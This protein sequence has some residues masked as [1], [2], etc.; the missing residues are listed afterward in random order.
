MKNI[1]NK[2]TGSNLALFLLIFVIAT[3]F[4]LFNLGFSDLWSDEIYT[5]SMLTGSL[6]DLYNKFRNDLHP[7]LYYLGLRLFTS[8]FGL[9]A[10][11]LRVFSILGVLSI[12]LLGYFAGQ[13]IFGKQGAVYFC[14]MLI[15]IPM[16]ALYSHEARMYTWAAFSVTGVF[17]YSCLFIKEAE[18]RDL[19]LLFVFT[20]AAMYIHYYSMVAAFVANA[21]VFIY[22]LLT[23]NKKW[24]HHLYSLILA[25]ILFLPW[26]SMFVVQFKKVQHAFWAPAVDFNTIL[27]CFTVPFSEQYWTTSLSIA[28]MISMYS[29]MIF[30]IYRSF[31]KSFSEYRIAFWLALSIFMGTL[32]VVTIISLF[33]SPI[34]YFRYVMT[35]VTMLIVPHTILFI[36][37]KTKLLKMVLLAVILFL[38][39]RVSISTFYFS[40]GPYKQTIDY[41]AKTY[42]DIHKVLHITE[43]TAGPMVE[44][45]GK[46]GLSHYWLKAKMSNVDAFPE[47]HQ[48]KQP[49]EFLQKGEVFC[50]VQFNNLELNKENL[51]LAI[52]ESELIKTDTVKD[53]KVENGIRILVYLLKYKGK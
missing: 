28:L 44:Y 34:L 21:F 1:F 19:L 37:M 51:D 32:L 10:I 14:L 39:I 27:S 8:V 11:S 42:P 40:W 30:A 12:L 13:R 3:F 15:S 53:N 47:V 46:S 5:K 2:L 35:I 52:S 20:A 22:L 23:K 33:S 24:V 17:I 38:G 43:I 25:A 4:Y 16:L 49:E 26:F 9:S 36:S 6:S 31:T 41:I 18:N 7:P 45:N 48:F 29:L 50:A